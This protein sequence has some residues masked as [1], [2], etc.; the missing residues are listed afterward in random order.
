M[1]T[2]NLQELLKQLVQERTK[3]VELKEKKDKEDFEDTK[4]GLISF[5]QDYKAEFYDLFKDNEEIFKDYRFGVLIEKIYICFGYNLPSDAKG[6]SFVI[7]VYDGYINRTIYRE[8]DF[9]KTKVL[10]NCEIENFKKSI[11]KFL[12]KQDEA[13]QKT[14]EWIEKV[15]INYNE[16]TLKIM[17]SL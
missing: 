13:Y 10:Y 16:K 14:K 1:E 6:I 8:N 3:A 12:E 7:N 15:I 17:K 11:K 9:F 5:I 2:K 4:N